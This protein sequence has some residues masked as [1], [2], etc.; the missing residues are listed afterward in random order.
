MDLLSVAE[1]AELKGCSRQ[2]VYDAM[3]AGKLTE[4]RVGSVRL[5][6]EDDNLAQWQPRPYGGL[7][8]G[9]TADRS[10]NSK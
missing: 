6:V 4:K 10:G 3:D 8:Q 1:T 7:R 5:V 2:A 9:A